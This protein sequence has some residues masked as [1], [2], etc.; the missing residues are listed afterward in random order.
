MV[1]LDGRDQKT[2]RK[3]TITGSLTFG[4][5]IRQIIP[6]RVN[7]KTIVQENLL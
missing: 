6:S 7:Q 5:G 4:Q 3:L 1:L 2:S